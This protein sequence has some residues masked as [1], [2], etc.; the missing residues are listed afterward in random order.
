MQTV[1]LQSFHVVFQVY[2]VAVLRT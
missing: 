1:V 2:P